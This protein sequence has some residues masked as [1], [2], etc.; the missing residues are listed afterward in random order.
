[1][2]SISD[3]ANLTVQKELTERGQICA[4]GVNSYVSYMLESCE[5]PNTKKV[6][7]DYTHTPNLEE[8][9]LKA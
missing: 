4:F 8:E 5:Y 6:T 9:A 2:E 7:H 3:I 1:M